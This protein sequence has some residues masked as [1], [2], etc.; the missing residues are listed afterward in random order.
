MASNDVPLETLEEYF[1]LEDKLIADLTEKAKKSFGSEIATL[2]NRDI[3]F[4]IDLLTGEEEYDPKCDGSDDDD[5]EQEIETR[6]EDF[7][8]LEIQQFQ[9]VVAPVKTEKYSR[10]KTRERRLKDYD[11]FVQDYPDLDDPTKANYVTTEVESKKDLYDEIDYFIKQ[12]ARHLVRHIIL[13]GHGTKYGAYSLETESGEKAY[14]RLEDVIQYVENCH[15]RHKI[16]KYDTLTHLVF[17]ICYGHKHKGT[18]DTQLE[19]HWFTDEHNKKILS[20][21]KTGC[22]GLAEYARRARERHPETQSLPHKGEG[23]QQSTFIAFAT[24]QSY[25]MDYSTYS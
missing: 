17:A 13:N 20:R 7:R 19:M 24:P 10:E 15:K 16:H 2:I 23:D 9:L 11:I 3:E 14:A 5:N 12:N 25:D 22:E 6:R 8:D 21:K 4:G 1:E 18:K